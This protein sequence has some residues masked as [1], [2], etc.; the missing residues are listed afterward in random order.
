MHCCGLRDSNCSDGAMPCIRRLAHVMK[1]VRG[2]AFACVALCSAALHFA[3]L[4]CAVR[5]GA[6]YC[7]LLCALP[8]NGGV[9]GYAK[10][11]LAKFCAAAASWL[12]M[13]KPVKG[14]RPADATIAVH[15]GEDKFHLSGPVGTSIAR[16][17]NFTFANTEE[18]KLWAEGTRPAYIYTRYG[19]PTL[20]VAEAKI[21]ALEGA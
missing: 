16:T 11:E 9:C 5:H 15:A 2:A 10:L 6:G 18:M 12:A 7:Y 4:H 1:R 20:S 3:A 17:A 8:R 14:R 19:N 21:A 13:K